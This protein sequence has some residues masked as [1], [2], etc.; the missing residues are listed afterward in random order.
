MNNNLTNLH[1]TIKPLIEEIVNHKLYPAIKTMEHMKIFMQ[2]H[3]YAVWDF[4]SLL[5]SLQQ[6]LTCVS[7][8]WFPVGD[9]NTRFLINEIVTGEESDVDLYGERKSHFEMYLEAMDQCG[10]DTS[11]IKIFI[12]T[13]K[14]T[15]HLESAFN[16]AG[17]PEPAK[18]FV[19]FTFDIVKSNKPPIQSAVFTYGREDL[20]PGMFVSIL[21]DLDKNFPNKINLFKYYI[22]RHIEVDGDHHSNL[23]IKMTNHLC[24]DDDA[25]WKEAEA[26]TIKA[27]EKRKQL[28]DGVL[29][30][31]LN[32]G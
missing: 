2:Y 24:G 12:K 1:F 26:N 9:A 15:N 21:N 17:T 32:A 20:I 29:Q 19:Q 11:G 3:V 23:A 31:I 18:S 4:M 14:D 10:A 27:L 22:E 13:L 7:V 5:K 28:W 8:P 6:N 16:A 25:S 30:E